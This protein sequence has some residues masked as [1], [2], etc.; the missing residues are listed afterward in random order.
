MIASNAV[1]RYSGTSPSVRAIAFI[2]ST[3]KPTICTAG[4]LEFVWGVRHVDA[5]DQL[6]G[7]RMSSGTVAAIDSTAP[8]AARRVPPSPSCW[9]RRPAGVPAVRPAAHRHTPNA[10]TAATSTTADGRP[11]ACAAT[12][13]GGPAAARRAECRP[14]CRSCAPAHSDAR[15]AAAASSAA[16]WYRFAG[17]LAMPLAMTSSNAASFGSNADGRGIGLHHVPGDLLFEA[18]RGIGPRHR[19]GI[20]RA[21]TS[22]RRCRT[23]ASPCPPSNRS[24]AM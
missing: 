7:D 9:P 10:P 8:G 3:S 1:S 17:F 2:R 15:R 20:R 14:D 22:A 19:S 11:R 4:V 6:A 23:S 18:L 13:A 24:G 16:L 21:R 12:I 5:D